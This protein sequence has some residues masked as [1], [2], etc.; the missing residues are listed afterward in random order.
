MGLKE[1][2]DAI[3][4]K[5]T[6]AETAYG[7]LLETLPDEFGEGPGQRTEKMEAE[8]KARFDTL[9]KL[10]KR[11][12]SMKA[13][14]QDELEYRT[15]K[16]EAE[17]VRG[18]SG[19]QTRESVTGSGASVEDKPIYADPDVG[20]GQQLRDI[21]IRGRNGRDVSKDAFQRSCSRLEKAENRR[22]H[23]MSRADTMTQMEKVP[24][25]GGIFLEI[26][27]S[28]DVLE[29]GYNNSELAKRCTRR[30]MSAITGRQ[31]IYG[32][33]GNLSRADGVRNGSVKWVPID[34]LEEIIRSQV[35]YE[36]KLTIQTT[37]VAA[38]Y[39]ASREI[40]D[41]VPFLT[42]EIND[43]FK[44]EW[45]FSL[46]SYIWEGAGGKEPMVGVKNAKAAYTQPKTATQGAGTVVWENII[47]MYMHMYGGGYK[48]AFWAKSKWL[49]Q[50]LIELQIDT[51]DS[52][53]LIMAY[54][55]GENPEMPSILYGHEAVT[56]EQADVP[57]TVGDIAFLDLSQYIITDKGS[58]TAASS[59]EVEFWSDQ[60]AFKFTVE[61]DG[62]SRVIDQITP[63]KAPS[64][65]VE[66]PFVFL[67]TRA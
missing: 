57:G 43:L 20:I 10:C 2:I 12:S 62:Q 34:E 24:S 31:E 6:D 26:E 4:V 13:A 51:G 54:K 9:D 36:N 11:E 42:G 3:N 28:Q 17:A 67:A 8:R 1:Q 38:G 63:Y 60:W 23:L 37:K 47:Q 49:E 7:E 39:N 58:M 46:Q 40:V 59:V 65:E 35:R 66:S 50:Q 44:K 48:N 32:L 5:I 14:Y 16:A 56:I 21:A 30:R 52:N 19:G 41:D 45:A 55:K 33:Q 15:R 27:R 61:I 53:V 29:I 25:L 64:G 18:V 22:I